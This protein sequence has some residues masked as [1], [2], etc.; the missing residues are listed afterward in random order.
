LVA[1]HIRR[2]REITLYCLL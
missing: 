2:F 1:K